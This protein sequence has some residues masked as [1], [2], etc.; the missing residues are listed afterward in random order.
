MEF[1]SDPWHNAAESTI[2]Q[3]STTYGES[4]RRESITLYIRTSAYVEG[5]IVSFGSSRL[6]NRLLQSFLI[7]VLGAAPIGATELP[8][9]S[10]FSWENDAFIPDE[11][12][13]VGEAKAT[14]LQHP[15]PAMVSLEA[16]PVSP[17]KVELGR[18]L[19]FDPLLS[20]DN[21]L[22]CAHCHHP[23]F[24]FADGRKTSMGAGGRGVGPD[25]EGGKVLT[26]AAPTIWNAAYSHLQFWDGRAADLEEQAA[27]PITSKEEM[28]ETP[29]NLIDELSVI[30]GYVERF[31]E[32]FPHTGGPLAQFRQRRPRHCFLRKN[33]P[34]VQLPI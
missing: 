7:V 4:Y 27:G 6:I 2:T 24:G 11:P 30:P 15:F 1:V 22:S 10:G 33:D 34:L 32:A 16:N 29:E 17:E 23:D 19:F 3:L 9:V 14:G 12:F 5:A 28:N 26:R 13:R 21:T 8:V 20:G 18:L 31:Q 25:R